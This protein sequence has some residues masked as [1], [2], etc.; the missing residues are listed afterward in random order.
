V[1][2][3]NPDRSLATGLSVPLGTETEPRGA[4]EPSRWLNAARPID[5]FIGTFLSSGNTSKPAPVL[6]VNSGRE[7]LRRD[8]RSAM[9]CSFSSL[10]PAAAGDGSLRPVKFGNAD[11]RRARALCLKS[12]AARSWSWRS[13]LFD[14]SSR[15]YA[16][17]SLASSSAARL[18]TRR[19]TNVNQG[20]VTI[21]AL[22]CCSMESQQCF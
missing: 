2:P 19:P 16:L 21:H 20:K 12:V 22:L 13:T 3:P 1:C 7:S 14:A 17:G 5:V 10:L 18:C 8:A 4:S 15:A 6:I 9:S 11:S